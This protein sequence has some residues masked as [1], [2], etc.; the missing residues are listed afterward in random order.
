MRLQTPC[1]NPKGCVQ[2]AATFCL[3]LSTTFEGAS[4]LSSSALCVQLFVYLGSSSF[5]S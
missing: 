3:S 2:L 1:R 4:T 5:P